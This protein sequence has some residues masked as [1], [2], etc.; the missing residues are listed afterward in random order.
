MPH[1]ARVR[2]CS[3]NERV[4]T[5]GLFGVTGLGHLYTC[6]FLALTGRGVRSTGYA[7]FTIQSIG[8]E[9]AMQGK[10]LMGVSLSRPDFG[11]RTAC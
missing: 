1:L 11:H 7:S 5:N 10:R 2:L 6:E 8:F 9:Q 4:D 3:F